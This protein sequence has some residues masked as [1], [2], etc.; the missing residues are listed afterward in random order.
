[1][2]YAMKQ[3]RFND[4]IDDL[5]RAGFGR[6]AATVHELLRLETTELDQ[7]LGVARRVRD[8]IKV[9]RQTVL[10]VAPEKDAAIDLPALELLR[11]V[12]AETRRRIGP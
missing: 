1:M 11:E 5:E 4:S 9:A 7:W 3:Y 8:T 10:D 6:L 12:E 2:K